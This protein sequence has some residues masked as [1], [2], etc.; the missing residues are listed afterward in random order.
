[1]EPQINELFP[2]LKADFDQCIARGS[3]HIL[4]THRAIRA[5]E[6]LENDVFA[7][8]VTSFRTEK[9]EI[10]AFQRLLAAI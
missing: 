3:E 5:A 1:M 6:V 7:R 10:D 9:A 4:G 8:L 2:S